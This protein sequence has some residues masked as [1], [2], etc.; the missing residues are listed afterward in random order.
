MIVCITGMPGS[1]KS[2]V[3]DVLKNKGYKVYELGD[4]VREEMRKR[5]IEMTS[6]SMRKFSL[7]FRKKYGNDVTSRRLLRERNIKQGGKTVISG[8]RNT[9]DLNYIK[10]RFDVILV[11]V[12][13]PA[14]TRFL[15]TKSR[16]RADN[17]KTMGEF[18]KHRDKKE[19]RFGILGIIKKA[20]YVI[21]NTGTVADLKRSVAIVAKDAGLF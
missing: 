11:A 16:V 9:A 18:I 19:T 4:V 14:K 1:G 6:E 2:V 3:A 10:R 20:D 5:K 8:L 12:I 21:S 15:R 13:A 17:P 7:Y